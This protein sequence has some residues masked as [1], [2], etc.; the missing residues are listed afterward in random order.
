[1][2]MA[3]QQSAVIERQ[4]SRDIASLRFATRRENMG[5]RADNSQCRKTRETSTVRL[6]RIL[7]ISSVLSHLTRLSCCVDSSIMDGD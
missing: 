5:F 1:M 7:D 6:G 4:L 2:V 3:I